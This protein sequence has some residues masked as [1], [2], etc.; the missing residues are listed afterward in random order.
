MSQNALHII[1]GAWRGPRLPW[2]P[3]SLVNRSSS[4]EMRPEIGTFAYQTGISWRWSVP[5]LSASMIT[6]KTPWAVA[7]GDK[8]GGVA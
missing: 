7:L 8:G 3:Q 6:N 2:V 4:R 5:I 1:G